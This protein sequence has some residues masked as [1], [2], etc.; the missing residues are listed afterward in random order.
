MAKCHICGGTGVLWSM[1]SW[2]THDGYTSSKCGY[3]GS[4]FRMR[5]CEQFQR[6]ARERIEAD[7]RWTSQSGANEIGWE[8]G[9]ITFRPAGMT[10]AE[11]LAEVARRGAR[12]A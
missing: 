2:F 11:A 8:A 7:R 4:G 3:C 1:R 6:T 5:D 12:P 9:V 10:A